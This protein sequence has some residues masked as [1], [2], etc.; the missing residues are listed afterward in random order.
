VN[1]SGL[2]PLLTAPLHAAN[3][4][5][6]AMDALRLIDAPLMY[7]PAAHPTEDVGTRAMLPPVAPVTLVE[8]AKQ[9]TKF[10]CRLDAADGMLNVSGW[11]PLLDTPLHTL[12]V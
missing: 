12:N 7:E 10:A 1:V 4:F 5:P 2:D 3:V 11:L 6:V 8:S 9:G